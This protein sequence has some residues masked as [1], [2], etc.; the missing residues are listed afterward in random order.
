MLLSWRRLIN[1]ADKAPRGET[2]S[3]NL[4]ELSDNAENQKLA[5][6]SP[7]SG[8]GNAPLPSI[9]YRLLGDAAFGCLASLGCSPEAAGGTVAVTLRARG[10]RRYGFAG[11]GTGLFA[12]G[13]PVVRRFRSR[14][15]PLFCAGACDILEDM[16]QEEV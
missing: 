3:I 5:A 7:C 12:P 6:S 11:G 1:L 15:L 14:G 13:W 10:G 2:Y 4:A 16:T 8:V 9:S